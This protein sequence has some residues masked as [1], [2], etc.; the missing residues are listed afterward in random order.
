MKNI[1][2]IHDPSV[3]LIA[4]E[5]EKEFLV[6]GNK[7]ISE[8][9]RKNDEISSIYLYFSKIFNHPSEVEIITQKSDHFYETPFLINYQFVLLQSFFLAIIFI[10]ILGFKFH[11]PKSVSIPIY[12]V[13]FYFSLAGYFEIGRKIKF[14]FLG[15]ELKFEIVESK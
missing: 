4:N 12:I 15:E 10:Q 9:F 7:A 1:H 11:Y 8:E 2:P 6:N 5:L 14:H 13:L 3:Y